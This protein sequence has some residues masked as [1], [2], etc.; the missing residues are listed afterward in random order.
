ML[1]LDNAFSHDEVREF[2]QRIRRFLKSD[3]PITYTIEPKYDGFA[4][5]LSYKKGMLEK[6][7]TRGDG[8]VGEDVTQ[9]IR[10]INAVPLK[11]EGDDVPE[12]I[13]IRGEVYMDIKD[14]EKLNLQRKK[15]GEPAF[16][17]P[18]NAAAGSVRQLEIGRAHV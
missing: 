14:F 5:E 7:S 10:T 15:D 18:R 4:I 16:A 12:E 8:Y 6:A 9:N 1:S 3:D 2:E 17:N 13:D 11:I